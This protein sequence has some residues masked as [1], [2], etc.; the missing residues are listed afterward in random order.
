MQHTEQIFLP[1]NGLLWLLFAC[2][3][4]CTLKAQPAEF[5]RPQLFPVLHSG[6]EVLSYLLLDYSNTQDPP[7]MLWL[8]VK[9]VYLLS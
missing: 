4:I 2:F 6:G 7:N 8:M 5:C 9:L 3:L 1:L